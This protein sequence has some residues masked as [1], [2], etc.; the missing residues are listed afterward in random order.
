MGMK[1][2][3]LLCLAFGFLAGLVVN[4][5]P[6]FAQF[7]QWTRDD[8]VPVVLVEPSLGRF[9]ARGT[10]AVAGT[11]S[12]DKVVPLL[13]VQSNNLGSFVAAGAGYGPTW[14]KDDIKAFIF[15]KPT[16]LGQFVPAN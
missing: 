5:K 13:L 3:A 2:T 9:I 15:V 12:R 16:P 14:E 8:V 11:W 1:S 6:V 7:I 4:P 10:T